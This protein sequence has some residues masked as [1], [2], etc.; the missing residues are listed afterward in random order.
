MMAFIIFFAILIAAL[1]TAAIRPATLEI[2][3]NFRIKS[4]TLSNLT[5]KQTFLYSLLFFG[6]VFFLD[7]F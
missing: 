7:S 2:L 4:Q 5:F 6:I 1:G 3:E